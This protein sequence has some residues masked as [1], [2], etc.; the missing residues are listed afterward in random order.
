MAISSVPFV[1]VVKAHFWNQRNFPVL[2]HTCIFSTESNFSSFLKNPVC[3]FLGRNNQYSKNIQV[4][5]LNSVC[6]QAGK[7]FVGKKF[8][9]VFQSITPIPSLHVHHFFST[10]LSAPFWQHQPKKNSLDAKKQVAGESIIITEHLFFDSTSRNC[11][12]F[13]SSHQ[14][15]LQPVLV[16]MIILR[17]V[18]LNK[19]FNYSREKKSS[20]QLSCTTC[21]VCFD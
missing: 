21:V 8:F 6:K 2:N 19:L 1:V 20:T 17:V 13:L 11:T 10:C 5:L 16:I 12:E 9:F 4:K 18:T 3:C 14:P 15:P 7:N